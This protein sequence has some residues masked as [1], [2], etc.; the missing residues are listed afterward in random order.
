MR[1]VGFGAVGT[2]ELVYT[3]QKGLVQS[4][5]GGSAGTTK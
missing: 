3:D 2:S 4:D 1:R 5:R